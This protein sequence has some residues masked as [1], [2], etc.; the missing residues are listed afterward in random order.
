MR[1]DPETL[2]ELRR[3][4][5][6]RSHGEHIDPHALHVLRDIIDGMLDDASDQ[7]SLSRC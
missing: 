1:I 3:R 5:G 6:Q 2:H 7:T 4:I